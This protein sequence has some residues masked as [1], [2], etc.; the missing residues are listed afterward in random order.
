MNKKAIKWGLVI[1]G[2]WFVILIAAAIFLPPH[3]TRFALTTVPLLALIVAWLL[4]TAIVLVLYFYRAW[5][6]LRTVPNKAAYAAWLSFQI[7]CTLAA[8]VMLVSSFVPSYVTSP[9]QAREWAPEQN[10]QLMRAIINQYTLDLRKRPQS[11]HD[12]VEAGY[13]KQ[14]PTDPITRRNDT[15]DLVWSN[16]P[17]MPGIVNIRSGSIATSSKG[18]AY[19]D[20]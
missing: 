5:L 4:L 19:H 1:P 12:L 13:I 3:S 16:D 15:W 6:R 20:W 14:T 17:K 11:L 18:S 9:R 10:L 2:G 8:A 7:A